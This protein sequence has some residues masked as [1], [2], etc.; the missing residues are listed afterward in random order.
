MFEDDPL[1]LELRNMAKRGTTITE[2]VGEINRMTRCGPRASC[3]I[4]IK[5][6][7]KAFHIGI[8]ETMELGHW[9]EF[10]GH[11]NE[12]EINVRLM[13][14]IKANRHLWDTDADA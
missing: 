3:I 7:T 9:A 6:L 4:S 5:Y 12:E 11:L 1:V 10:G 8:K 2:L 13:T 14:L